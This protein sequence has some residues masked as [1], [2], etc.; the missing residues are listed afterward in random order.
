MFED[1]GS[2]TETF[3]DEGLDRMTIDFYAV[4]ESMKDI[5]PQKAVIT[6][7]A[8][9][10]LRKSGIEGIIF[11]LRKVYL[12]CERELEESTEDVELT[13]EDI[14]IDQVKFEKGKL[15]FYITSLEIDMQK[16]E[17][18]RKFKYTIYIGSNE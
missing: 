7:D 16:Q 5:T 9:I 3:V 15:P 6:Y 13:Y 17:D 8:E 11:T 18:P 4:P 1:F 14:D 2:G 12:L 10:E